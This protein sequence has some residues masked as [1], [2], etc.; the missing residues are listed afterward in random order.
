MTPLEQDRPGDATAAPEEHLANPAPASNPALADLAPG[1]VFIR[2]STGLPAGLPEGEKIR[3]S[4]WCW[5]T[6]VTE[7]QLQSTLKAA[8]WKWYLIGEKITVKVF[9]EPGAEIMDKL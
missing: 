3:F 7:E 9:G 1:A 8:G 2:T 6:G 5:H 4:H